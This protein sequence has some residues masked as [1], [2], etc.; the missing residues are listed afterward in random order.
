MKFLAIALA[1]SG[2]ASAA[3]LNAQAIPARVLDHEVAVG[4]TDPALV[5]RVV[6]AAAADLIP[7]A[8]FTTVN[9]A[10]IRREAGATENDVADAV[11]CTSVAA[12]RGT[13]TLRGID[14]R[15]RGKRLSVE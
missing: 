2:V 13:S 3:S 6:I 14:S 10:A 15:A 11:R 1:V 4:I 9:V 7:G 8:V 12:V 5:N